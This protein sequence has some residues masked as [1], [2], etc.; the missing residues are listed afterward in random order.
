MAVLLGYGLAS[1]YAAFWDRGLYADGA[2]YLLTVARNGGFNLFD[3]PRMTVQVLRKAP[4]VFAYWATTLNL[5]QLGVI[6]SAAML[7]TPPLLCGLCWPILPRQYK[8]WITFP[9]LQLLAGVS[10]SSFAAVGEGAIAASYWWLLLFLLAFRTRRLISQIF[11]LILFVPAL[12]LHEMAFLL[13]LVLLVLCTLR[14]STAHGSQERVFLAVSGLLAVAIVMYEIWWIIEPRSQED[15]ASYA[16]ALL[17]L[18]FVATRGRVN[19]PVV[20]GGLRL[21]CSWP[22]L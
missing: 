13:M 1:L 16:D 15:R 6:F 14:W 10:A 11:C 2:H 5:A 17:K 3:P 8:P 20:T 9:L 21:P 7:L 22:S 18:V 4:L 19:L 12:C